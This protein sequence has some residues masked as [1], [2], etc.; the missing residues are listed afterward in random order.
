MC[1]HRTGKTKGEEK[2]ERRDD[3]EML[4]IRGSGSVEASRRISIG[5]VSPRTPPQ[6]GEGGDSTGRATRYTVE[7]GGGFQ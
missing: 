6:A 3:V 2:G 5:G 4:P 7:S 1:E